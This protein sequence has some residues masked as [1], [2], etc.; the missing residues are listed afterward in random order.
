[1][2]I[3][4]DGQRALKVALL[5]PGHLF[6]STSFVWHKSAGQPPTVAYIHRN[7]TAETLQA[8]EARIPYLTSGPLATS[9]W[10]EMVFAGGEHRI[11]VIA[12]DV[13]DQRIVWSAVLDSHVVA[14]RL[15]FSF[16]YGITSGAFVLF[17]TP[18]ELIR[19]CVC[20]GPTKPEWFEF[21]FLRTRISVDLGNNWPL[22]S[23]GGAFTHLGRPLLVQ[24]GSRSGT[25]LAHPQRG[26]PKS[27][28]TTITPLPAI[29]VYQAI[30][31]MFAGAKDGL[32]NGLVAAAATD[33]PLLRAAAMSS[34][35][36]GAMQTVNWIK[37]VEDSSPMHEFIER[38]QDGGDLGLR[39]RTHDDG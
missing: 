30:S 17:L 39:Y 5:Y 18:E 32:L 4:D 12:C 25:T 37:K 7:M 14:P 38:L 19:V 35:S 33:T 31:Q 11:P 2:T 22:F 8:C 20:E 29:H 1:M 34:A 36:V 24:S 13:F 16:L 21:G 9:E 10:L 3:T 27:T 6:P 26:M 28:T 23:M 15:T